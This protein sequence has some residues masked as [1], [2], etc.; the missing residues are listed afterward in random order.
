MP[1]VSWLIV[2]VGALGNFIVGVVTFLRNTKSATNRWFGLFSLFLALYLILN[3][4]SISQDNSD[5]TLFWIRSVMVVAPAIVFS[6][7]M[8]VEAFPRDK[9]NISRRLFIGSLLSTVFV[10][11]LGTTPLFFESVSIS[12]SVQPT[13]GKLIPIFILYNIFFLGWSVYVLI[14][15]LR[16]SS[17]LVKKQIKYFLLGAIIM[18]SLILFSNVLLVVVFGIS[19]LVI[20]VP[21]YTLA[22]VGIVSYAIVQFGMF[23]VRIIATEATIVVLWMVLFSKIVTAQNN[24]EMLVDSI[25]F[26]SVLILGVLLMRSVSKEVKQRKELEELTKKLQAMDKQKDEFI[27]M[28]AHELRAP[29]TAIRGYVSMLLD[30]DAGELSDTAREYLT[31]ANSVTERLVRLVN[32]MLNVGRIEEGRMIFKKEVAK[33]SDV[34]HQIWVSF[35]FEAQRKKLEFGLNI[36]ENIKDTVYVDVDKLNEVLGNLV[37]NAVKYTDKGRIDINLKQPSQD[38]IRVEVI[39]TGPGISQEEQSKLFQKFY[40]VESAVGKTIGTGLG[41]Y[42][43]QLLIGKFGGTIGLESKTGKGSNFWFELPVVGKDFSPPKDFEESS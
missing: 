7:F 15:K 29:M 42:I 33:L 31:D 21:I 27:S 35:K 39:D 20:L 24:S 41:L 40:R 23:D 26:V 25:V 17:G 10:M 28:V 8:L 3:Q 11:V 36:P 16:K 19:D 37:S 32:N 4:L 38:L 12:P 5:S 1:E 2:I 13:P 6:F 34:A 30:G 43:S 14:Q 22:F 18:F 9:S